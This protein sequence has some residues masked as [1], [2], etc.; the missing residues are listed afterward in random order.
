MTDLKVQKNE[1]VWVQYFNMN[2]EIL[3]IV[4]SN[5][6]REM[7]FLYKVVDG[8]LTKSRYKNR[9]PTELEKYIYRKSWERK[10]RI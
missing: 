2:N 10:G 9:D 3:G 5:K 7:Y 1:R 8:R 6:N 4:T